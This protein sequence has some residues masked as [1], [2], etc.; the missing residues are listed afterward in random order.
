MREYNILLLSEDTRVSAS[1][2]EGK[3]KE[4]R[5]D[6][7]VI[8]SDDTITV[9]T[10]S[11]AGIGI[12][13]FVGIG[14]KA[15]E[16]RLQAQAAGKPALLCDIN[17][18]QAALDGI[19]A[20]IPYT[21]GLF[22]KNNKD[23]EKAFLRHYNLSF[24]YDD[25]NGD[26][27]DYIAP[28]VFH[29]LEE[30]SFHSKYNTNFGYKKQAEFIHEF[31]RFY[32]DKMKKLVEADGFVR[33]DIKGDFY[34]IIYRYRPMDANKPFRSAD[35]RDYDFVIEYHRGKPSEG[36]YYGV[37]GEVQEDDK[38]EEQ[39]EE[40][41]KEWPN[42]FM[43]EHTHRNLLTN[44]Q[45]ATTDILNDSFIWK[46]FLKCIKPTDNFNK[47]RYWLFWITLNDDEDIISVAALAVKLISRTFEEYLWKKTAFVDRE[48]KK[49]RGRGRPPKWDKKDNYL[50]IPYFSDEAYRLLCESYGSK[51]T[52]DDW[53]GFM[54]TEEIIHKEPLFD[55]CYRLDIDA[56]EFIQKYVKSSDNEHD[57]E[58]PFK[59]VSRSTTMYYY[60]LL[61]RL[62][63]LKD[64]NKSEGYFRQLGRNE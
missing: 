64:G 54:Q 7:S 20:T 45:K 16:A 61:D 33:E 62:F 39:C 24:V 56:K 17:C 3:I 21:W 5:S 28:L 11:D 22:G 9:L 29:L 50:H 25:D 57:I 23:K 10:S 36:I 55:K 43:K 51:T 19:D 46:D 35:G 59:K 37:K 8:T 38:L 2:I 44:L 1:D 26:I 4:L 32:L 6:D 53:T 60:D 63:M 31:T 14:D 27:A 41:H 47:K 12:D 42:I 48:G 52:L 18:P 34:H 13:V 30:F 15:E 40:F 58:S 49:K